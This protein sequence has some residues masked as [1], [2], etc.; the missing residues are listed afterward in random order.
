VTIGDS[1]YV[2]GGVYS[3]CNADLAAGSE[4]VLVLAPMADG[5]M[6]V[7]VELLTRDGRVEVLSPDADSLAAFGSNP[8]DPAVRSPAGRAGYSQGQR[9]AAAIADWWTA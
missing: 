8:L 7:Q 4:R 9:S 3:S 1:R 5:E 6:P 2:D